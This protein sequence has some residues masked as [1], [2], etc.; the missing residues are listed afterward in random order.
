MPTFRTAVAT[1]TAALLTGGLIGARSLP[2][3]AA[4][5]TT[6]IT[7][8]VV[9]Y[10]ENVSF[11]HYFGTYPVASNPP[12]EPEFK[13][14]PNTPRVNGLHGD[15]LTRNPNFVNQA[16]GV[17]AANP[18]RLDRTQ[19][20]TADQNH[21]YTAEQRAYHNGLM[22]LFP[23]YTGRISSGGSGAFNTTG[24]VMG[25]FDGN[26]V[27]ALW[28]YAQHFAMSDN[29]YSDQFGPSTPGAINLISGQTNGLTIALGTKRSFAV[30]DGQGGLTMI[31][32]V[33][34]GGDACSSQVSQATLAGW[35]VGDLLG[36]AGI[37][38]GWFQGGFDLTVTNANGTTGCARTTW[39]DVVNR[40]I[41]DYVPHHEPFQYYA[42]TANPA[43][44]R[45]ASPARIGSSDDGGANHQYDIHD[46]YDAVRAGNFPA[47]S[48]LKAPAHQNGHAGNSDPI[49]EQR[50]VVDVL[51][52]L[53]ARPD[54]STTAVI[55]AYDDSD[56]W[57]DHQMA[58]LDNASFDSTAD[59]LSGP[60]ACGI[61]GTTRQAVGVTGPQPVNGRCGP[62]TR[63]PFLVIS[64]WAR[65]NY[66]D[67]ALITQ[68]S[69]VRFIEDNWLRSAR[70]GGG[71]FDATAGLINGMF[72]F[73]GV[74]H[75]PAL[76]VSPESG[77][78]Q[79]PGKRPPGE[80]RTP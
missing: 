37:S 64:P 39:S 49:D 69:V 47:V 54:W 75:V 55:I 33:D 5:T 45:P 65:T 66:V 2:R 8:L 60:G 41:A 1:M 19:A 48:F 51:N 52:F 70:L 57:Y 23:M 80:P 24:L 16:N 58:P 29:A 27:T 10:G 13:A 79:D 43:H 30:D 62:G 74:G 73:A 35:N 22:D 77:S 32:D 11:D 36:A 12:G 15:L 71:S 7:H 25:Y 28:N 78:I 31:G 56:G 9:I 26:T 46:F 34:P 38:W 17:G 4:P 61:R 6:P 63:Q 53:Q 40:A 18:F 20:A 67:H 68:A 44:V 42:S 59:Q 21:A 3:A 76:L 14:L 50:F 72:D